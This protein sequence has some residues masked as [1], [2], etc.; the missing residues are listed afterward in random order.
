VVTGPTVITPLMRQAR[1]NKAAASLLK[2]EGI[3]NDPVG[4]LLAVLTFQYFTVANA[5]FSESLVSLG[6]AVAGGHAGPSGSCPSCSS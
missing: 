5:E 2:W 1:L 6:S 3:S 4:V